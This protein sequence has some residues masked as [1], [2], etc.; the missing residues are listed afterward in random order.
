MANRLLLLLL[1]CALRPTSSLDLIS[2]PVSS[3]SLCCA[4]LNSFLS[5]FCF[6]FFICTPYVL[7]TTCDPPTVGRGRLVLLTF[8]PIV[9]DPTT[10]TADSST[11]GDHV[12]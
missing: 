3:F 11:T 5:F 12:D 6:C 8:F 9:D 4:V 7:R 10:S 1:L 2:L